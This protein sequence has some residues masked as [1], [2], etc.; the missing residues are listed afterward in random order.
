V[1]HR[2]VAGGCAEAV[3]DF[4]A[5]GDVACLLLGGVGSCRYRDPPPMTLVNSMLR[6]DRG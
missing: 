1:D 2:H 5:F 6:K 3:E 4:A